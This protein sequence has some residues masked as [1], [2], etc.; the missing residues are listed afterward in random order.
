MWWIVRCA[1]PPVNNYFNSLSFGGKKARRS[2]LEL[3]TFLYKNSFKELDM[4]LKPVESARFGAGFLVS[5]EDGQLQ[6]YVSKT[7]FL[8]DGDLIFIRHIHVSYVEVA[9]AGF[10]PVPTC[11]FY[12]FMALKSRQ[13]G[14]VLQETF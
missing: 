12:A 10:I 9:F 3:T 2:G 1:Y 6:L 4:F 8:V 13:F 14:R 5:H 7:L 11:P